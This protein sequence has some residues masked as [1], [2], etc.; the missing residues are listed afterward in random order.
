M[1]ASLQLPHVGRRAGRR[2]DSSSFK[3]PPKTEF[4]CQSRYS[5]TK[6][7]RNFAWKAF[8]KMEELHMPTENI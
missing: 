8:T 1:E 4:V 5:D 2:S 6:M 3:L 7:K